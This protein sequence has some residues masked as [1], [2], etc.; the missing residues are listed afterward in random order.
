[1]IIP[2]LL[3]AFLPSMAG[4][5]LLSAIGNVHVGGGTVTATLKQ[6]EFGLASSKPRQVA[7]DDPSTI[8]EDQTVSYRA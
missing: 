7:Q 2:F 1:M 3:C 8:L 6:Y 5:Y 4:I